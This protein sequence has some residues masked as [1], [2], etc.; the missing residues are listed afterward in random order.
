MANARVQQAIIELVTLSQPNARVQQAIVE[1][2]TLGAPNPYARVQQAVIELIVLGNTTPVSTLPFS[3][4]LRG[5]K[6][7]PISK[8]QPICKP[9]EE[10]L[11]AELLDDLKKFIG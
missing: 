10:S 5:V 4:I 3:V 2:I 9:V 1:M 11:S 8:P 7:F 6:R